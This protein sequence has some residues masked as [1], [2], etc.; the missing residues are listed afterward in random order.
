MIV[1]F[2]ISTLEF[3]EML[4]NVQNKK[5]S[6]LGPKMPDL[7]ILS[8]KFEKSITIFGNQHPRIFQNV[9]IKNP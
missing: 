1:I 2:G 3:V 9:K 6:N 5:K 4:K 8:Y 7:G